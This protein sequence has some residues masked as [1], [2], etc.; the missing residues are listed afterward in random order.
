MLARALLHI[1]GQHGLTISHA[2]HLTGNFNSHLRDCVFLFADEAFY[3]GDRQHVGVLKALITEPTLTVEA[4]YANATQT[5]NFIH[6]MMASNEEWVVPASL[7][8]RRFLV[9][10]TLATYVGNRKYFAAIQN[11]MEAGGYEAMLH[12]LL[13][14]DISSFDVADVPHTEGLDEQKKLSLAT[15]EAWWLDVLH[16]GYVWKSKLGLDAH[17]G[18]WHEVVT[19]E[20]L[21]MSY[22]EFAKAKNERHPMEREAFGRFMV[23]MGATPARHRS[24]VVGEHQT[25]RPSGPY[26]DTRRTAAL[27]EKTRATGYRIGTLDDARAAFINATNLTAEWTR[28]EDAPEEV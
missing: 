11:E 28:A 5:P 26:G 7:E 14:R 19:T 23:R 10:L 6:L 20:I 3:A 2:K 17:F 22:A 4:K 16:R 27:I 21:F 13:Q 12:D 15:S 1:M 25:D 9:L 8:A 24:G 18:E